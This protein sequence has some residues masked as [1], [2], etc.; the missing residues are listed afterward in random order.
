MNARSQLLKIAT[1]TAAAALAASAAL[2]GDLNP[3]PGPITPTGF[4]IAEIKAEIDAITADA[5]AAN[6]T[7]LGVRAPTDIL[8]LP[9]QGDADFII[10]AP[11][12]YVLTDNY[13]GDGAND[14]LEIQSSNV[15]VDLKGFAVIGGGYFDAENAWAITTTAGVNNVAVL[16]G[17]IAEF[18]DPGGGAVRL[19]GEGNVIRDLRVSVSQGSGIR[20]GGNS[21]VERCSV[22]GAG[23]GIRA[24]FSSVV[25]DCTVSQT[26][27]VG[28]T[29][30]SGSVVENCAA[31]GNNGGFEAGQG[32][33]IEGCVAA[34]NDGYGFDLFASTI[35]ES[36]AHE[37]GEDGV[38]AYGSTMFAVH[39][40]NNVGIGFLLLAGNHVTRCSATSNDVGGYLISGVRNHVASNFAAEHFGGAYAFRLS[41]SATDCFVVSNFAQGSSIYYDFDTTDG[42]LGDRKI[43]LTGAT[44]WDNF[45][46]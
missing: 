11:G 36:A 15:I 3:P 39:S 46:N 22:F 4:T 6:D 25:K 23:S 37:N 26:S 7:L 20:T 19:L 35:R 10:T 21:T 33:V 24:G 30:E 12:Y 14:F 18:G 32:T 34:Q 42:A 31:S 45:S 38:R 41:A 43:N 40:S 2:A 17:T 1:A 5:E 29:L 8:T 27:G 13:F 16:N 9:G 28:F 44:I